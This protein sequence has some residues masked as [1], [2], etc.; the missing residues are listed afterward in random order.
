MWLL[1]NSVM[2]SMREAKSVG[3]APTADQQLQYSARISDAGSGD[4]S[5]IMSVAGDKAE[6]TIKG[7]LTKTPDFM[8][9]LFGGGNT[10][11]SDIN[12]ALAAA[13]SDPTINSTNLLID[14]PGGHING[15]FDTIAALQTF[16]KT[17]TC[18]VD[19]ICASAAYAIA[20]QAQKIEATN[21]A[22]SFGSIG[23]VVDAFIDE[24]QV[25]ITSTNAPNKRPDISTE[26]GKAVVVE[27]LDAIHELF[28]DAI[29]TGR[30]KTE[31]EV[32][33]TFGRGS[34]ILANEAIKRGMID[35]I[36][37]ANLR[38]VDSSQK[39]NAR[40]GDNNLESSMDI[41]QLQATHPQLFAEVIKKGEAQGVESER[42]RVSSHLVMGSSSGDMKTAIEAIKEGSEM[43]ATLQATYLSAG[44]NRSDISARANEDLAATAG[45]NANQ[46]LPQGADE[47]AEVL[48]IL[49]ENI[50]AEV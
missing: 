47:G 49:Q 20:S 48:A 15:L 11:Y 45:D 13:S 41:T 39:L 10:T 22:S 18:T 14:S 25:S 28:V 9:M 34:M 46:E 50:G 2:Q 32:N 31:K 26:E 21:K 27:E 7:V 33:A 12:A 44:M 40:G 16:G 23:I 35:G 8:A 38:V 6:I 17:L 1:D 36:A 3:V 29:A 30:G 43:T 42:D 24:G 4:H 37:G 5:R 19:G